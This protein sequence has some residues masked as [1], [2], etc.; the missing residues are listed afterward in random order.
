[1]RTRTTCFFFFL[2]LLRFFHFAYHRANISATNPSLCG[3]L[4]S[5]S[6]LLL[7]CSREEPVLHTINPLFPVAVFLCSFMLF[8]EWQL[9]CCM[10]FRYY[11]HV[12]T[13]FYIINK[14]KSDSTLFTCTKSR[15]PMSL[16]RGA[17]PSATFTI[18]IN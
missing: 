5:L 11:S 13:F 8:P 15:S 4:Q 3:Y 17:I 14:S 10:C 16:M 2:F 6:I 9:S 7:M 1:M 18:T 12:H